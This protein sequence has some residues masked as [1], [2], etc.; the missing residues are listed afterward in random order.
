MIWISKSS[1]LDKESVELNVSHLPSVG[2][3]RPHSSARAPAGGAPDGHIAAVAEQGR[4]GDCLGGHF[5][6]L[7]KKCRDWSI[8]LR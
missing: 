8:T 7:R 2:S 3:E 6:E 5:C 4:V 1:W